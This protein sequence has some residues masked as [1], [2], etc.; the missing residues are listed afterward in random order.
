M[1]RPPALAAACL[2]VGLSAASAA[3]WPQWRGPNRDGVS[4]ETGL[5]KAWPKEGPKLL[6]KADLGGV[7]Y[8]S[9][10]VAAGRLYVAAAT[11]PDKGTGEFA[12]CLGAADGKQLWKVSLPAGDGGYDHGY[13]NGPRS[14]PTVDG[15][16]VYVLGARG[17]LVCLKAADGGTVWA[18]NLKKDFGGSIPNWGC[19]ESVLV[20]GDKLV[21]TPGG[22]KG[23]LLALDKKTGKPLWRAT[24][25]KDGAGYAS[26]VAGDIAGV[27]Q[28]VTQTSSA[29]VGVRASDGKLLWRVAELRRSVAVIPTPVV[30]GNL[31]FF[32]SGY[33]AGCE[34]IQ[35]ESAGDGAVKAAPVY[36]KNPAVSNHHGGVVR[37]GEYLYGHSDRGGWFCYDF[38]KGGEDY[39]W[40]S[41]TPGKGSVTAAG[42]MLYCLD[43]DPKKGLLVLAEASPDG[44]KERGRLELPEK[45]KFPR[46]GGSLWTHPVVADGRLYLRDHELLF[47]YDVAAAK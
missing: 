34:L 17:D 21:C 42:G 29:A 5:L 26:V 32:T 7:G 10:V 31:A 37:V 35:V 38:K 13:G 33:N 23:T 43:Q 1:R 24:D 44:W 8:S 12:A 18:V 39:V 45:S 15:D 14:S 40:Q 16:H 25:L 36:T 11:D 6:W 3:D 2:V 22:S 20:D 19:A 27:R 28:Y 9:P 47:C 30:D 4:A 46:K 41:K